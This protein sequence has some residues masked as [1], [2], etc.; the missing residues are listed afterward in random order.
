MK[1]DSA[2]TREMGNGG[3]GNT[4]SMRLIRVDTR[5]CLLTRLRRNVSFVDP[6]API[7]IGTIGSHCRPVLR[8]DIKGLT[9][10]YIYIRYIK[11]W[12]HADRVDRI[13]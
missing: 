3:H 6:M 1:E 2:H 7:G 11:Y 4:V 10:S 5:Y 8:I 9:Y 13:V 12:Y